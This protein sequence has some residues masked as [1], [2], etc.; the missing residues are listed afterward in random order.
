MSRPGARVR[1]RRGRPT[2]PDGIGA[3]A[4]T[5]TEPIIGLLRSLGV[6]DGP[7]VTLRA[8]RLSDSEGGV[9]YAIASEIAGDALVQASVGDSVV[10]EQAMVTM[11]ANGAFGPATKRAVEWRL[12][13]KQVDGLASSPLRTVWVVELPT[14]FQQVRVATRNPTTGVGSMGALDLHV[15]SG[16]PS[17]I[18]ALLAEMGRALPTPFVDPRVGSL[19]PRNK[20][21]VEDA[22]TTAS[23]WRGPWAAALRAYQRREYAAVAAATDGISAAD[24]DDEWARELARWRDEP[25]RALAASRLRGAAAMGLELALAH[26]QGANTEKAAQY[27]RLAEAAR[28]VLRD[29]TGTS[30]FTALWELTRL[31]LLLLTSDFTAVGKAG[32][33]VPINELSPA[34]VAEW[35]NARGLAR[36]A[37]SRQALWDRPTNTQVLA[38]TPSSFDR[39]L[40][41]ANER[42]AAIAEYRRALDA[43]P[44][45]AEAQ[46]RLGRVLFEDGR[47]AEALPYLTAAAT[48][49]C[50][51]IICGLGWL[52]LGDSQAKHGTAENAWDAYLQASRVLDVRQ[53]AL[54]ALL[55]LRLLESPRAAAELVRQFD[56]TSMLGRQQAPDAWSRY[57]ASS[58]IGLPSV[59]AALREGASQ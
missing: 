47:A 36:E 14:G 2:R 48:R 49:N 25:D 30:P 57:L 53:S 8:F 55:R 42:A 56:S 3:T 17:E 23:S 46:L 54:V 13:R 37:Q 35:Y 29:R 20:A 45:H 28:D 5:S 4:P 1:T 15:E 38:L 58:P 11:D 6:D 9:H 44:S 31:Y 39:E 22:A 24:L 10:F 27:L 50:S 7:D 12:P 18:P 51:A 34:F 26:A 40:W 19:L 21:P 43:M 41:I 32:A 52:F 16:A 33:R 59:V